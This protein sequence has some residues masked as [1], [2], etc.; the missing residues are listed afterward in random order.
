V[1]I[2]LLRHRVPGWSA[3]IALHAMLIA[4]IVALV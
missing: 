1:A 4:L 3:Y 2:V